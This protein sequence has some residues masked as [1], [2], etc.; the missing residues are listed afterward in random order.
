MVQPFCLFKHVFTEHAL[1]QTG[2]GD[3][4]H[5]V[6]MPRVDGLGQVDSVARAF[7]VHGYLSLLIGA[8]VV[9][10]SQVVKMIDLALELL[11]IFPR[12]TQLLGGE[13]TKHRHSP[14]GT[15]AP[16]TAQICHLGGAFL[17]NQKVHHSAFALQ[18]LFDQPLADESRCTCH[19]ILH[20]K[21]L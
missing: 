17:A 1:I 7:N 2:G 20:E 11:D 3:G 5:M 21:L 19:K 9:Y 13:I 16:E 15:H 18:K 10:R 4:R 8:Q 12:H 6:K 14:G